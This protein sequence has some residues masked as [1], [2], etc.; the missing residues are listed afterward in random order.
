VAAWQ[1]VRADDARRQAEADRRDADDARRAAEASEREERRA[2]AA[3]AEAA[4]YARD[5]RDFLISVLT[6]S[7]PASQAVARRTVDP[8]LPV[9]AALDHAAAR[10]GDAYRDRPRDEARLRATVARIYFELKLFA[11]AVGHWEKALAICEQRLPADHPERLEVTTALGEG[12]R[13]VGRLDDAE[14]LLRAAVDGYRRTLG[15]HPETFRAE[16]NLGLLLQSKRRYADAEPVLRAAL[17]GR[18]AVLGDRHA[19]TLKS[20]NNLALCL[21]WQE[22]YADAE[23]LLR[24]AL[25]GR[26][27]VLGE[28]HPDTISTIGNLAEVYRYWGKP[29][30]ARP[31]FEEAAASAERAEPEAVTTPA[32]R[33]A[34]GRFLYECGLYADAEPHLLAAHPRLTAAARGQAA[35]MLADIY[36]ST[37][38]PE[39]AAE[40]EALASPRR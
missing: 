29:L 4:G 16:N 3:E 28:L 24:E 39:R 21:Y 10:I 37:C 34:L 2:R 12:Y 35:R 40:W 31:L 36:G 33:L 22:R 8:N 15:G 23:P 13:Q 6:Q 7:S 14:R 32:R 25:A 1:A 5:D 30:L 20:A 19:D 17:A 18:R 27:D 26:R 9:K 38:R 11:A